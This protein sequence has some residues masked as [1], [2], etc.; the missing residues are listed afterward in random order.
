MKIILLC[1]VFYFYSFSVFLQACGNEPK[2]LSHKEMNRQKF[3]KAEN[4]WY[5]EEESKY[6]EILSDVMFLTFKKDTPKN[7]INQFINAGNL[8]V[9]NIGP[10]GIYELEVKKDQ[11][12][13][14]LYLQLRQSKLVEGID[15]KKSA[16]TIVD[17]SRIT[18][19]I[20]DKRKFVKKEKNWYM[21][22]VGDLFEIIPRSLSL[23]FRDDVSSSNR[24][25]FLNA[26]SFKVIR[27]NRLGIYDL[28][29]PAEKN[30]IDYYFD[31]QDYPLLEFIEL[32]TL[33][34]YN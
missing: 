32:N 23:K 16:E 20:Y 5:L 3:V 2:A 25:K 22:S 17:P 18:E 10:D 9:K 11:E 24:Q 1:F 27:Q 14:D 30:V 29:T 13:F 4:V 28:K 7:D 31:L 8:K 15:I 26:H 33:G 34:T 21:E 6:Y 19:I 12:L